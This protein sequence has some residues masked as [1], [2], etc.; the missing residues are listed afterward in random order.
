MWKCG[1]KEEIFLKLGGG[2]G[3]YLVQ[4]NVRVANVRFFLGGLDLKKSGIHFYVWHSLPR[5]YNVIDS[6]SKP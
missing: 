1:K 2:G 4:S 6:R 3:V 5:R